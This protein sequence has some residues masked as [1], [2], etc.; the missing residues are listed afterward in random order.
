[1]NDFRAS[2]EQMHTK[3]RFQRSSGISRR[4]FLNRSFLVTAGLAFSGC[5]DLLT[6]PPVTYSHQYRV[7]IVGAGLSGLVA[8]YELAKLGFDVTIL[9]AATRVGGRVFTLRD[10][11][12][13]GLFAEAG[14]ARIPPNHDLTLRYVREFNLEL[15]PFYPRTGNYLNYFSG[16]R[17]HLSVNRFLQ[18]RPWP[19]SVVHGDY[20]KIRGGTDRLPKA[21]AEVLKD[22][23][24]LG[25]PVSVIDQ[26]SDS[27]RVVTSEGEEYWGDRVIVTVPLPVLNK[28]QFIPALSGVKQ[29]AANGGFRYGSA[30]RV[31]LQTNERFWESEGLNGY[32]RTDWPEEIWHP[33]VDQ[34]SARGILLTYV[35]GDRAREIDATGNK[36]RILGLIDRWKTV[37][38]GLDTH[39]ELGASHSWNQYE[40]SLGAYASPTRSQRA[41]FDGHLRAPEGRIHFAGE[42]ISDYHAWMQG[43]LQSGLRVVGE[44]Q[45]QLVMTSHQS[46]LTT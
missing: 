7:I 27:V 30:S 18:Q 3:D 19:G 32:A 46:L 42:H 2:S 26:T 23:I 17:S 37:F 20:L 10:P 12:S 4:A 39:V 5:S 15:D 13:D 40:W 21:F 11:F 16:T 14:A 6:V 31:Y 8:G 38:R 24:V 9:E 33:T 45:R 28:I 34:P 43:A 35:F 44:I 25:S 22:T 29:E 41:T 1:M 36:E